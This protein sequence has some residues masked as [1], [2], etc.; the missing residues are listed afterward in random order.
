M[1]NK[2]QTLVL[3]LVLFPIFVIVFISFY[4]V[5]SIA[6]EKNKIR[7]S[8]K[9]SLEYG[10]NNIDD[11][12]VNEKIV[13]MITKENPNIKEEN[14]T[15]DKKDN[16]ITITVIKKYLISFIV[17]DELKISYTGKMILSEIEI[18]ENRG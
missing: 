14:I 13:E 7:D 16:E 6:L 9:E 5:G 3:F 11:I 10:V 18:I 4:Q 15:I 8:I 17:E 1:N 2:G 12:L